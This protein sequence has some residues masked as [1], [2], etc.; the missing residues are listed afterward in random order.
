MLSG[1]PHLTVRDPNCQLGRAVYQCDSSDSL[2][3]DGESEKMLFKLSPSNSDE[4]ELSHWW[5]TGK[6]TNVTVRIPDC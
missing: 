5:S 6:S 2:L 3:S 4:S 1:F